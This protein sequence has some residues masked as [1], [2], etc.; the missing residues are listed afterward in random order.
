MI[1]ASQRGYEKIECINQEM[2]TKYNLFDQLIKKMKIE[3]Q[4][5]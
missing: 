5:K 2:R 4:R 3:L 1:S